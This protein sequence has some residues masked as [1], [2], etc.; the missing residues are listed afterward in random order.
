MGKALDGLGVLTRASRSRKVTFI[1]GLPLYVQSRLYNVAVVVSGGKIHGLV[2]KTYIPNYR[3]FYEQRWFAS[4]RDL[5]IKEIEL[6]GR[7]IPIGMDLLFKFQNIPGLTLGVEICEDLWVPLPPSSY[8]ALAGATI[9]ANLSASNDLVGKEDYRKDLVIGQSGR[10]ISGYIYASTG[11]HESTTDLV[12]GGHSII[13]ENGSLL[14]E[15]NQLTDF[16]RESRLLISEIDL[17]HLESDRAHMNSFAESVRT[18]NLFDFRVVDMAQSAPKLGNL[19]RKVN[20]TPFIPSDS[21]ERDK[22]A[23]RIFALQVMALAKRLESANINRMLIGIS[24]G[25]DSTLALLVAVKTAEALNLP[26]KNVYAI[27]MPGFGTSSRTKNNARELCPAL[28]VNFEEI[29]IKPG[30]LRQLRDIKHDMSDVKGI[31]YQNAQARY[32]TYTLMDKAN[33]LHGLVL[34]TGNLSE[35]ALGWNTYTGDHIAHYN[36]NVSVPKTLVKY[37]VRWVAETQVDTRARKV[38]EDVLDTPISPELEKSKNGE[39]AHTTEEAIGPYALHDFFLYH[40]VRWGSNPRKILWLAKL[41]WGPRT[42]PPSA[43]GSGLHK[44]Y[45][46]RTLKK[47][48]G[49]F[50]KR[51]FGNQWKRSVATDGPKIGS[52]SLSP[53]GDWRMPSDAEVSI[54]LKDL[55]GA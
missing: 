55:G 39:I 26:R 31:V 22:R 4:G 23:S 37:I 24:G 35:I 7:T 1:V 50:I 51:F 28:G 43:D 19:K 33:Q 27:T 16:S 46:E 13:A 44:K 9:I 2:P 40:F 20:P 30:V 29:D 14:A 48:L 11:A 3:E 6:F 5:P 10:T 34:G 42:S 25:L 12:F 53:R 21:S 54:W 45:S 52:V 41:A 49:V 8:Q 18:V 32:R 36:P 38:L 15:Q 17:E 47:W